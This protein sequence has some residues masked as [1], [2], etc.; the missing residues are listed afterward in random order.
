MKILALDFSSPERSAAALDPRSRTETA[1]EVIEKGSR[2]MQP[3]GLVDGALK[4]A[5]LEREQIECVVVGLGPGSY[6]GIR[7]AI[8]LAQ[9][10][11]LA[12]EIKILG[13][14]SIEGIAAQASAE[15]ITGRFHVVVDAQRNELYLAGY[16]QD[17]NGFRPTGTL[18]LVSILEAQK[19]LA[20]GET[21]VGPETTRWFPHGVIVFPRAATLA[22]M[23]LGRTDFI[24]GEKIEPIYLRQT[25]FIKAPPPRALTR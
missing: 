7:A 25:S 3:L 1:T 4:G 10:W 8:S 22:R 24:A 20:T 5:G 17:P 2:S 13:L 15:G 16:E 12:R 11:Q 18:H 19:L 6:T 23:A 9:G 14:S 21:V